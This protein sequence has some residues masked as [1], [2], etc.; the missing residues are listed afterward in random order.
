MSYLEKTTSGM[1]DGNL[2]IWTLSFWMKRAKLGSEQFLWSWGENNSN[3]GKLLF[4]SGDLSLS[5]VSA[6]TSVGSIVPAI[7]V[8]LSGIGATSSVGAIRPAD[9]VG[10]TG[11]GSTVSLGS[12]TITETQLVTITAPSGL[13]SSVGSIISE[14]TVPLTAPSSL[15][16]SVGS[17]SPANVVGITGLEAT[18]SLGEIGGPIAWSLIDPSQDG[19]WSQEIPTQDGGW[20]QIIL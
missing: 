16:A 7:V 15:T 4:G 2:K 3:D 5:G 18:V 11:L 13:T 1:S 14:I 19:N 6:T 10:L 8:P 17:I 12:L 20:N 9:V